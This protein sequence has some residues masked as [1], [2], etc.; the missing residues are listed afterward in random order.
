MRCVVTGGGTAGVCCA[1]K[2]RRQQSESGVK[3]TAQDGTVQ[4][5]FGTEVTEASNISKKNWNRM[6]NS[7]TWSL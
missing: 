4:V 7:T 1:E 5:L 3:G 6:H 2:L